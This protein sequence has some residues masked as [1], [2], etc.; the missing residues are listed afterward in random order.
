MDTED[1]LTHYLTWR[2]ERRRC[3]TLRGMRV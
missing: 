1:K 3:G 2:V